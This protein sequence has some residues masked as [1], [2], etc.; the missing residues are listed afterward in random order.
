MFLTTVF[1][2]LF[3]EVFAVYG[4]NL[5]KNSLALGHIQDTPGMVPASIPEPKSLGIKA[6]IPDRVEIPNNKE[7][8]GYDDDAWH[9]RCKGFLALVLDSKGGVKCML[10]TKHERYCKGKCVFEKDL[11]FCSSKHTYTNP[12]SCDG[13]CEI[14]DGKL[15]GKCLEGIDIKPDIKP[16]ASSNNVT[17]NTTD[18][19]LPHN[20]TNTTTDIP[21]LNKSEGNE[22]VT[23][24]SI[25]STPN[26]TE[27]PLNKSKGNEVVTPISIPLTPSATERDQKTNIVPLNTPASS[28]EP[29]QTNT[30]DKYEHLG[31]LAALIFLFYLM[32]WFINNLNLRC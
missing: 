20:N 25:P 27:T 11:N 29:V 12:K 10:C 19:V 14:I 17:L 1:I 8:C 28:G 2:F 18:E 21:P 9:K 31:V 13:I 22:V 7:D 6:D 16:S 24:I 26:G 15:T 4:A 3:V 30:S 5:D 32:Y 23:P